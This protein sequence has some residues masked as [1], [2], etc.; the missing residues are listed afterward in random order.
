MCGLHPMLSWWST[1]VWRFIWTQI[2]FS[3]VLD[4]W[5][6][7][8]YLEALLFLQMQAVRIGDLFSYSQ[9]PH[10]SAIASNTVRNRK[11]ENNFKRTADKIRL[12]L[13]FISCYYLPASFYYGG[14]LD[15]AV[16]LM[17]STT[18]YLYGVNITN[19]VS[20]AMYLIIYFNYE[21]DNLF[22]GTLNLTIWW[23]QDVRNNMYLFL[24]QP[25]LRLLTPH[26]VIHQAV[27]TALLI[28]FPLV[29]FKCFKLIFLIFP[30]RIMQLKF[31]D[32][33]HQ[34][35]EILY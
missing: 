33:P 23:L 31:L 2:Q 18:T 12:L 10:A 9:Q 34:V 1:L 14:A 7:R 11:H 19:S 5:I 20:G 25:I 13:K 4:P 3:Y 15:V 21:Q 30:L 8:D 24:D 32:P 26:L 29:G 28:F 27:C 6:R 16:L 22:L 35:L 17:H